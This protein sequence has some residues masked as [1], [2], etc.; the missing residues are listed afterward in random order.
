MGRTL[1]V[2]KQ[3][4]GPS[5]RSAHSLAFDTNRSRVVLF[6]GSIASVSTP[7]MI[8]GGDTWEWNGD[9][10]TQVDDIGPSPRKWFAMAHDRNRKRLVLFGGLTADGPSSETWE[11]DGQDWTQVS[12]SGPPARVLHAMAFDSSKNVV[13]LFGG[14]LHQ[15]DP[16]GATGVLNDTLNDTWEWNGVD[17]AQQEDTGPARS[18]HAMAYDDNRKRLVVFGGVN[19]QGQELGDTWEWDGTTWTQRADFG[20]PPCL[21]ASLVFTG[22]ECLLFGGTHLNAP[23][24]QTWTWDGTHWTAR[25]DIGPSARSEQAAALDSVRHR[26]VLFGGQDQARSPLGDTWEQKVDAP[27]TTGLVL[28]NFTVTDLTRTIRTETSGRLTGQATVQLS[29]LA[30][31]NGAVVVLS[32]PNPTGPGVHLNQEATI[33]GGQTGLQTQIEVFY[34]GTSPTSVEITARLQNGN[35]LTQVAQVI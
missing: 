5:R 30:P 25:Q 24:K 20:P 29:G 22:V 1:W 10:W 9:N 21:S 34:E 19:A 33:P 3:N 32:G 7:P 4:F 14:Q 26:V 2:Q 15:S 35:S 27:Q 28:S 18:T 16:T 13:T 31:A 17:W 11:W 6:G 8:L 12:E 23:Q